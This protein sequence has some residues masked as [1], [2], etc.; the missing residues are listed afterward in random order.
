MIVIATHNNNKCLFRLLDSIPENIIKNEQILIVDTCSVQNLNELEVEV[1][2]KYPNIQIDRTEG[3]NYDT[4]AYIHAYKKYISEDY[5]F[6][7][8]SLQVLD[9]NFLEE[10]RKKSDNKFV[11]PWLGVSPFYTAYQQVHFDILSNLFKEK[12]PLDSCPNYAFFGPIFYIS[13]KN[14]SMIESNGF[15]NYIPSDKTGA[16][17]TE[18]VWALWAYKSGL[19][20]K[21]YSED[22]I[23][24]FTGGTTPLFKKYLIGRS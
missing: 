8:D 20:V 13:R 10:F 5:L 21:P 16:Q 2:T 12:H 17:S 14:M 9:I 24:V 6:L 11:V 19:E 15:L 3:R 7:H 4:G 23:N 18:Q 22:W 1:I